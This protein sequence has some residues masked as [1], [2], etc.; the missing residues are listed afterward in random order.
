MRFYSNKWER[1]QEY[2]LDKEPPK[3][4]KFKDNG[5]QSFLFGKIWKYMRDS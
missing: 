3:E 5:E 1:L 4:M 2:S